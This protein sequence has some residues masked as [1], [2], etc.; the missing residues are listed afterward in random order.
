MGHH[1]VHPLKAGTARQSTAVGMYLSKQA[2]QLRADAVSIELGRPD[3]VH[4]MRSTVRRLRSA[5]ATF[6]L[7]R[8]AVSQRALAGLKRLTRLLAEA[9][10]TQVLHHRIVFLSER[11]PGLDAVVA[12]LAREEALALALVRETMRD[13]RCEALAVDIEALASRLPP[14]S[15]KAVRR[16]LRSR[17]ARLSKLVQAAGVPGSDASTALHAV[18]KQSRLIRYA[19]EAGGAGA[20]KL[21]QLQGAHA[22]EIQDVLGEHQDAVLAGQ[23]FRRLSGRLLNEETAV[24]L[25]AVEE[26]RRRNAADQ[27]SLIWDRIQP[28]SRKGPRRK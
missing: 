26:A 5:L 1:K 8:T 28:A 16:R 21:W 9:R 7:P 4:D 22:K 27:F 11:H 18:R 10:E 25:S 15:G 24:L 2:A 13:G 17:W 20:G 23:F 19:A 3:A 12:S 6:G 14:V